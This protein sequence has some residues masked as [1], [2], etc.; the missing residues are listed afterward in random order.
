MNL[1][2]KRLLVRVACH[3]PVLIAVGIFAL[4]YNLSGREISGGLI[5]FLLLYVATLRVNPLPRVIERK[6]LR[7]A[8]CP[9]CG[10]VIDLVNTW[11]CGCGFLVWIPRHAFSSCP[12]CRKVFSWLVCP[13]CEASIPL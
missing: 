2:T 12:H 11:N 5:I 10:E 13:R 4:I 1:R 7:I 9:G 8:E 6:M 3:L